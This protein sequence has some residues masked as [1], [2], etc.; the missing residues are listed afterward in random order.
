MPSF[1][2]IIPARYHSR[3]LPGKPLL[4]IAGKS[5]LQRVYE[6]T[7]KSLDFVYIATDDQRIADHVTAFGGEV[8]MTSE[9]HQSGTDRCLEALTKIRVQHPQTVDVVINIQGDEPLL[10]PAQID[11][12]KTCFEDADTEFATLV[13]PVTKAEDL[14]N[15][16]E[17]FVTFDKNY[18]ALYFSRSVIPYILNLSKADW[19][20][21]T[22]FYKHLGFY[23]Y[24]TAALA[25]FT[26]LPPSNLERLESL[27]QNRWLENGGK[28]KVAIT[29]HDTIGIDTLDDLERVR[30]LLEER[31]F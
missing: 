6:Q 18:N 22:T 28:I 11:T 24:T 4:E 31:K 10:V 19:L 3:R 1:I 5:M 26:K 8:I 17:V 14:D 30:G 29:K 25:K 16:G 23:A 2:A 27:E 15:E 12:L 9:D 21:H 13:V 20:E 7:K